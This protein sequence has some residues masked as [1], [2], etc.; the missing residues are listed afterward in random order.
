MQ[1]PPPKSLSWTDVL[2]ALRS[3]E[4][5]SV[6]IADGK[7]SEPAAA[8]R[9]R[10]AAKGTELCLFPGDKAAKRTALIESLE[11]FEKGSG[12]RFMTSARA[13]VNASFLL[14]EAVG[15]EVIDGVTYAVV[16]TRRPVL[17]FNRS[18]QTGSTTT[19]R[20]KRIKNK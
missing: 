6:M 7:V 14:V 8:I 20:S 5:D 19:F 11:T 17:G 2:A 18:Q 12:R 15:D 10:P 1:T 16:K 4:A 3:S 13:S 9:T